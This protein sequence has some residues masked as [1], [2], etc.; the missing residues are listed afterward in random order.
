MCDRRIDFSP[1]GH[2]VIYFSPTYFLSLFHTHTR[3]LARLHTNA[4][5][6]QDKQEITLRIA[7]LSRIKP[8]N[9]RTCASESMYN[10]PQSVHVHMAKK[11]VKLN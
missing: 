10:M 1:H 5:T 3:V 9:G 6:H 4:H 8:W 11:S 7:T 2:P